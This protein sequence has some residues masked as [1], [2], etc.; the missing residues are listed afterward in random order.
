[1][2]EK[3]NKDLVE[4]EILMRSGH[5]IRSYFAWI[6]LRKKLYDFTLS[7]DLGAK[8]DILNFLIPYADVAMMRGI[9]GRGR[10]HISMIIG[11]L[12]VILF[13]LI[14]LPTLFILIPVL[15]VIFAYLVFSPE[16]PEHKFISAKNG[17]LWISKFRSHGHLD[18]EHFS[19]D[20]D[21]I[22]FKYIDTHLANASVMSLIG[23]VV[24]IYHEMNDRKLLGYE[25]EYV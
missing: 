9:A 7:L 20:I 16:N 19:R 6:S 5:S 22:T 4:M 24:G 10:F 23:E 3:L 8:H 17:K 21:G 13:G 12:S 25:E 18:G 14:Y 2:L 15:M 11:L 1:M